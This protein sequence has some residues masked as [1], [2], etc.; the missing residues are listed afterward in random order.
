MLPSLTCFQPGA[1]FRNGEP[2]P[3]RSFG[4]ARLGG[5]CAFAAAQKRLAFGAPD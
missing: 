5:G 2:I 4:K 3:P 1:Y